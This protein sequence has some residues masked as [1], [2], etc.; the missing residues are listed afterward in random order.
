[1]TI[2]ANVNGTNATNSNLCDPVNGIAPIESVV[3]GPLYVA[4][5]REWTN[6]IRV[7]SKDDGAVFSVE[8][9]TPAY[10]TYVTT[11]HSYVCG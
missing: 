4:S 10:A 2:L 8:M 3:I 1:M 5:R 9:T 7:V 6:R 11:S